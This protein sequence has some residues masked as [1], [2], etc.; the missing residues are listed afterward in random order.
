MALLLAFIVKVC[1]IGCGK[2]LLL[3]M[4]VVTLLALLLMWLIVAF[5]LSQILGSAALGHLI[6]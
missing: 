3:L 4:V 2:I 6:T 1:K 5:V